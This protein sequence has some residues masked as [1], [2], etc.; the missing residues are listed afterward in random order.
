MAQ[1]PLHPDRIRF[2]LRRLR[3]VP[4]GQWTL[5]EK[6]LI[7]ESSIAAL[8]LVRKGQLAMGLTPDVADAGRLLVQL[9][10]IIQ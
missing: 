10:R 4:V 3:G 8:E 9:M 2:V 7:V 1:P 5:E 6:T